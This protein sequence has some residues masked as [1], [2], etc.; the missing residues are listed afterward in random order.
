MSISLTYVSVINILYDFGVGPVTLAG[1]ESGAIDTNS[2]RLGDTLPQA[3]EWLWNI[4]LLTG[5]I[6]GF[7][8][9]RLLIR[10]RQTSPTIDHRA[11]RTLL[12]VFMVGYLGVMVFR[13]PCF[14]RYFLPILPAL[15]VLI[16]CSRQPAPGR[17][18]FVAS[19]G[20]LLILACFGTLGTRDYLERERTRWSLLNELLEQGVSPTRIDGGV[21]FGGRYIWDPRSYDVGFAVDDEYILAY[22]ETL[23]GYTAV[24]SR[25]LQ[26][27]LPPGVEQV[28]ILRRVEHQTAPRRDVPTLPSEAGT[29]E[30]G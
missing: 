9:L 12:F 11:S 15:I 30:G 25:T 2:V 21:Q 28:F 26:R 23:P 16:L 20:F 27:L 8:V 19:L 22:V 14:D 29:E 1:M 5:L 7:H 18:R 17:P 3:P 13:W 10:F 4:M 24:A 6:G